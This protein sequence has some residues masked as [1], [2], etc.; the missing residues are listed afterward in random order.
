ANYLAGGV[1][2]GP[3]VSANL[4]PDPSDKPARLTFDQFLHV[5]RTG[6]DPD[7]PGFL[8]Q[9]RSRQVPEAKMCHEGLES[10]TR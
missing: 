9:V 2:F 1:H 5:L 10:P 3:F 7:H 6:D 4:T 8:L